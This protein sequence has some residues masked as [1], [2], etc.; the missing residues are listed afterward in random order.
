MISET[1]EVSVIIVFLYYPKIS[2]ILLKQWGGAV[3]VSNKEVEIEN[4]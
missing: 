4:G 1:E 3:M 2:Q